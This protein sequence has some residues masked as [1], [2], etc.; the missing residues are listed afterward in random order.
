MTTAAAPCEALG[1]FSLPRCRSKQAL[2]RCDAHVGAPQALIAQNVPGATSCKKTL[3]LVTPSFHCPLTTIRLSRPQSLPCTVRPLVHAQVLLDGQDGV[4][5]LLA[6]VHTIDGS[7]KGHNIS[8]G[9]EQREKF[10]KCCLRRVIDDMVATRRNRTLASLQG[11]T[12]TQQQ[13]VIMV[14]GD[15]NLQSKS[16][17]ECVQDLGPSI[18]TPLTAVGE[19]W[20]E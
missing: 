2:R 16:V 20:G 6:N 18:T 11:Q 19:G 1:C 5:I 15:L 13:P 14:C 10:K 3:A 12:E 7:S 8:G 17:V 4:R 9:A